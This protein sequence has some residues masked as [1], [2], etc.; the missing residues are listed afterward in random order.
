MIVLTH[1][2][3]L[4]RE[5][6]GKHDNRVRLFL[7]LNVQCWVCRTVR[8]V[9]HYGGQEM[10]DEFLMDP[11]DALDRLVSCIQS[12]HDSRGVKG[13]PRNQMC[14]SCGVI[15]MIPNEEDL[16]V[17]LW[18]DVNTSTLTRAL[19]RLEARREKVSGYEANKYYCFVVDTDDR[20]SLGITDL[21]IYLGGTH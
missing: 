21:P 3:V 12:Q 13:Q 8:K 17:S 14:P 19:Q 5:Y 20:A 6:G 7:E 11:T 1:E 4:H 9:S 10:T 16:K 15:S 18:V 2:P